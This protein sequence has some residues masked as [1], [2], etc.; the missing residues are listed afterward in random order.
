MATDPSSR[1]QASCQPQ[2]RIAI[3]GMGCRFPG[4]VSNPSALWDLLSHPEDLSMPIPSWRLRKEGFYHKDASH[5]GTT[6]S[7]GSYFMDDDDV[8]MFDAQ[9]F[10]IAP[11][12]AESM[13]PQHRLLLEVVYEGLEDA[14]ISLEATSGTS[15]SAYVGLMTTDWQDLQLRD[16]DDAPRYL[17]TGGARSIA[18]NRLSYFYNWHGPSETIDTACSS[19][20][21]AVHHAV[22][23]LRSGEASMAVA[24]GTNLLLAPEM[25]IMTSNLNMLSSTGKCQ[26]WSSD[27]DGYARGEGVACVILKTLSSALAAND[28]IYAVIRETG[29]NQDGRTSGITMPSPVAQSRLI[30]DTYARAGLDITRKEDQCQFFEAHGTGTPAGDPLEAQAIWDAFFPGRQEAKETSDVSTTGPEELYVGSVKTVMGH[31]EGCAGL[32]GLLKAALSV[33]R[34]F[35]LPNLHLGTPNSKIVPF[36]GPGKMA[37]ATDMIPWPGRDNKMPRRASVNSFGF[38]GT[39]SHAILESY[40]DSELQEQNPSDIVANPISQGSNQPHAPVI[41]VLSAASE[42]ALAA[43]TSQYADYIEK[44]PEADLR[45]LALTTQRRRTRL[46]HGMSFSGRTRAGLVRQMRTALQAFQDGGKLGVMTSSTRCLNKPVEILGVFTGQGAQWAGMGVKLLDSCPIFA[47][48]IAALDHA[49]AKTMAEEQQLSEDGTKPWSLIAELRAPA[50]TS[51]VGVAEFAQPLSTAVQIALVD[52]LH[53]A[54]VRFSAVVGHSSG[55]LAASYAAG[56]TSAVDCVRMAYYRGRFSMLARSPTRDAATDEYKK[57]GMMAASLS[58]EEALAICAEEEL[59]LD[60]SVWVAANNAPKSVTLSGDLDKLRD[61][62]AVFRDRNIPA[63]ML[64]VDRAYHSPHMVPSG[65]AYRQKLTEC[66]LEGPPSLKE[67]CTT[68]WA[69]SVYPDWDPMSAQDPD[70]VSETVKNAQYWVENMLSPVLFREALEKTASQGDIAVILEVGPHPALRRQVNDTWAAKGNSSSYHGTL[71]RGADDAESLAGLFGFLW[72]HGVPVDLDI[73]DSGSRSQESSGVP[74]E[75]KSALIPLPGLPTMPWQ[76]NR[77]YWCESAKAAQLIRRDAANCLLGHC[78][79]SGSSYGGTQPI[80]KEKPDAGCFVRLT[81]WSWRQVLRLNELPW[82][83]GHKVQGQVVFPAA[84][85]CV[86]AMEAAKQVAQGVRGLPEIGLDTSTTLEVVELAD[87]EFGR[88]V[89]FP[90][91]GNQGVSISL[92]LHDIQFRRHHTRSGSEDATMDFCAAFYIEAQ[93]GAVGEPGRANVPHVACSGRILGMVASS[94]TKPAYTDAMPHYVKD[95][96]YLHSVPASSVYE[97]YAGIGLEYSKPFRVDTVERCLGRARSTV[98]LANVLPEASEQEE[99]C[100]PVALLDNAFQTSLAGFTAPGDGKLL[101]PYLPRIIRRLRVDL[102]AYETVA[103]SDTRIL[104]DATLVGQTEPKEGE[105]DSEGSSGTTTG[106]WVANIE[107]VVMESESQGNLPEEANRMM[108]QVEDLQCVNLVPTQGPYQEGIFSEEIW[109][110][111]TP[112]ALDEFVLEEDGAED[113]DAL[114]VVEQLTHYHMCQVYETFSADEARDEAKTPWFIRRF[115]NWIHHHFTRDGQDVYQ[116]PWRDDPG[117]VERLMRR[118]ESAKHRVEVEIL[119]AVAQNIVRVMRQGEGPTLLEVL[120]ENDMLARLYTEPV[121]YARANRYLGR[122]AGKI[123]HRFPRCKILEIGAGTGGAT[124]AMFNGLDGA[125]SSYTFTDISSS[126]FEKAK[127]K[128]KNEADR[129]IFKTLDVEKDVTEQGFSPG[130]YD[131][132]V[133]SNVLHATKDIERSLANARRLLKP[134]GY[135]L[136]LEITAVDKVLVPFLMGAVPGWWL[137]EDKWRSGTYSPLLTTSKWDEVLRQ[138]GYDTGTEF[139][140]HDMQD[141][142]LTSVM[143]ARATDQEWNAFQSGFVTPKTAFKTNSLMIVAG[144]D[145]IDDGK[146][147]SSS[148]RL[149]AGVASAMSRFSNTTNHEHPLQMVTVNGLEAAAAS[150]L[151]GKSML[152]VLSDLDKP[153]L[154]NTKPAEWEA[155][156]DVFARASH[157][158]IWVTKRRL[159]GADPKQSMIVGMGRC[160]RQENPALKLRFIDVDDDECTDAIRILALMT[161]QARVLTPVVA[162]DAGSPGEPAWLYSTEFEVAVDKGRL[163]L[164]RLVPL[165]DANKRYLARRAGFVPDDENHVAE[166]DED[167]KQVKVNGKLDG[168]PQPHSQHPLSPP[169]SEDGSSYPSFSPDAALRLSYPYGLRLNGP[170]KS[171]VFISLSKKGETEKAIV[172]SAR[173]PD[174]PSIDPT[175]AGAFPVCAPEG[176]WKSADAEEAFLSAVVFCLAASMVFQTTDDCGEESA[177]VMVIEPD[178]AFGY[179][180][181]LLAEQHKRHLYVVTPRPPPE[182]RYGNVADASAFVSYLHPSLSA[183]KVKKLLS[184]HRTG[185][186]VDHG[187]FK[188]PGFCA[189]ARFTAMNSNLPKEWKRFTQEEELLERVN[190]KLPATPPGQI[191]A[192]L[193]NTSLPVSA[194]RLSMLVGNAS[195]LAVEMVSTSDAPFRANKVA[196]LD[197]DKSETKTTTTM[198]SKHERP[199]LLPS[200]R[201]LFH[202]DKTYVFAGITSDLGLLV[203]KWMA[204]NGARSFA[205]TSRNPDIPPIW[206]QEMRKLGAEDVRVFSMDVTDPDSVTRTCDTIGRTMAAPVGGVVLGAMVL[207]DTLMENMPLETLQATMAP[208]VKGSGLIEDYFR[209]APLDFFIFMSSMS[210]VVGIRGQSNYCAGNMYGRALVANRRGRGLAASTIDLSTV[211]GVGHFAN[212]GAANL[213]TVHANLEGFNTLAIGEAELIDSF[214]EAIL[215]GPPDASSTGEVT[216]GLGSETAVAGP[217]RPPQPAAWHN[218]PRFA[219]FTARAGDQQDGLRRGGGKKPGAAGGSTRNT[220]EELARSTS[221]EARLA[222]LSGCFVERIQEIMQLAASSLRTDVPLTDLGI[223]SLVAVDLRGWFFKELGVSVPVLSILNGESVKNVCQTVLSQVQLDV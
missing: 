77:V 57:G 222:T 105:E 6:N 159:R 3:V 202:P 22:Q 4:K 48:T 102:A 41:I 188:G 147:P 196:M 24:A 148:H 97:A 144:P 186:V 161:C 58:M 125:Y 198:P 175:H 185:I 217:D 117:R 131:V 84:G 23:S 136:I 180:L 126:F 35:I 7:R 15:T 197:W 193:S 50:N 199:R 171:P 61:L 112:D 18:S 70:A 20:L 143:V 145:Q 200:P 203:A 133:A 73:L 135:L 54:G 141:E 78:T 129:I 81:G 174:G 87:V 100:F 177:A 178:A 168:M 155:L 59:K 107:G 108:L 142:H 101:S 221:E 220:R 47:R 223:D 56:L 152:L 206:L 149:A 17:V 132:V 103:K 28:H 208:K 106:T 13:D 62:K 111:D 207:R 191:K 114:D 71:N 27:A 83:N 116:N 33:Q 166:D 43:L 92:H 218:D 158:I 124:R 123:S 96:V 173:C 187:S 91:K 122:V 156:K 176:L 89:V 170:Q 85:Y 12:E 14:G 38:G 63:Q 26:M 184:R 205:L 160:A 109:A 79:K 42:P 66:Q 151:L 31:L 2:E 183:H 167:D 138:V 214:H 121:M 60:G 53:A 94:P 46:A 65:D 169:L 195:A 127:A 40:D 219:N 72:Q 37:V 164:P 210:A 69:S 45:R 10:N 19:S 212:A 74:A 157:E 8:K 140:Y 1:Y 67:P 190:K 162:Q 44:H 30:R 82:L 110:P 32:A 34:G 216:V 172:I 49:L 128:F 104:L 119:Q 9:F 163:M 39:N 25:Y 179:A 120:F 5:H 76:H 165:H 139:V 29:V 204:E 36:L 209:D 51:R 181:G 52:V 215:R 16:I 75:D 95:A 113:H 182:E 211:F 201:S 98:E 192:P 88:A 194:S 130:T 118:V 153:V 150:P 115:W 93:P 137:F 146:K 134:G 21:V 11:H 99:S 64:K 68:T 213:D 80:D 189:D 86:M 55:E 90:D 154:D